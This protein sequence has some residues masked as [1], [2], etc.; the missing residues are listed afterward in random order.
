MQEFLFK[1]GL[2]WIWERLTGR[3][4]LRLLV[5]KANF[6]NNPTP[7]YFINATN[8]SK[9]RELEI[10]HVWF[11]TKPEVPVLEPTRPLPKRLK[12]DESWETWIGVNQISPTS[13]QNPYELARAK[14]SS[15]KVIKSKKNENVPSQGAVPGP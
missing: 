1:I 14:L 13:N 7:F 11:D 5:H 8:L 10:T 9:S 4:Q 15:G 3:R 2:G 6:R 12:P